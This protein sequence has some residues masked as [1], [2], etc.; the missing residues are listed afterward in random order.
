MIL[1][2]E[3]FRNACKLILAA[4]DSKEATLFTETLELK[5]VKADP[6]AILKLNVTNREYFVTIEFPLSEYEAMDAAVNASVF[7][8]LI[9]KLTTDTIEIAKEKTYIKLKGNGDYKLPIIFNNDK[10]VELPTIE[11]ENVTNT[12]NINSDILHSIAQYNSKELQ[13][14]EGTRPVQ[15]YYYVD[16]HGAITFTSGACVNSFALDTPIKVLLSDKVVKLFRLF[17]PNTSVEFLMGQDPITEDL[18]QTKVRFSTP[19]ITITAKLSD[20]GLI[21]SV[22]VS[23]IRGM[24]NKDYKY[25]VVFNKEVLLDSISRLLLLNESPYGYFEF[26]KDKVNIQDNS[27]ENTETVSYVNSC[28]A[29]DKYELILNI[30]NLKLILD[31]VE[32]EYITANFGDER[33]VVFKN[34][35]IVNIIQEV[36]IR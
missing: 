9:S 14:G 31:T 15:K 3:D 10:M 12:M 34:N 5:T 4:I 7:L 25:S 32:E 26:T 23:A 35:N 29:L 21:S 24:A 13:R 19:G 6:G 27:K 16:E 36:K 17:K 28:E 30:S 2:T 1:K 8:R 18:I 20:S 11:I 22:P 33:A